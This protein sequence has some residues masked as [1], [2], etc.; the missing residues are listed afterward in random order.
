MNS[1]LEWESNRSS[2]QALLAQASDQGAGIAFLPECFTSMSNG[3]IPTPYLMQADHLKCSIFKDLSDLAKKYQ[4]KL[5][6]GSAATQTAD[7][8]LNRVYNLNEHGELI[9]TYDKRRLFA[10]KINE[11]SI[12]ESDIYTAGNQ[13]T[14]LPIGELKIGIGVC[15]DIRFS[16]FAL[17]YRLMGA[18]A[19]TYASAFTV[20]TGKAHWHLLN[21]ARAVETQSFVISSA[22]WGEHN[23]RIQTFGHSLVVSPWGDVLLDLED[24][25]GVAT[26][27][28]DLESIQKVRNSVLMN[29]ER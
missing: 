18:N 24:G 20:P 23:E 28:L 3:L 10:C 27:D 14:L 15:F 22:Q 8:I 5:I 6:G 21:R 11:K 12:T 4:I 2:L 9:S 7:G 19:L 1:K 16:E 29:R 26:L 17:E 25:V 13:A